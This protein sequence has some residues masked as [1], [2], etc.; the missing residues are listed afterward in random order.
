MSDV[1]SAV[2]RCGTTGPARTERWRSSLA[3]VALLPHVIAGTRALL[4][5]VI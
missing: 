2:S 1:A 4:C 5:T 3:L